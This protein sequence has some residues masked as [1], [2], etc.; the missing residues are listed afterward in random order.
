MGSEITLASI[1]KIRDQR[2][3][4]PNLVI[5]TAKN[6]PIQT[7]TSSDTKFAAN[8]ASE[9]ESTSTRFKQQEA[10]QLQTVPIRVPGD[11]GF[12]D[13]YALLDTCSTAY[14]ILNRNVNNL[15]IQ[16]KRTIELQI[17][18]IYEQSFLKA[19]ILILKVGTYNSKR[20]FFT[21]INVHAVNSMKLRLTDAKH[22]NEICQTFTHL[23]HVTQFS[24]ASSG[25][26]RIPVHRNT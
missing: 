13:C 22:L 25:H 21:L 24:P 17:T 6:T 19:V 10:S 26:R 9:S 7:I 14:Y 4:P 3:L 5:L 1:V 15:G 8:N 18:S 2:P 11:Q 12:V 20:L 16:Q 23:N